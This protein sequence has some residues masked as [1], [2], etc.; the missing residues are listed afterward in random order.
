MRALLA[1][2]ERVYRGAFLGRTMPVLWEATSALGPEGW[3]V[4][5]LTDNYLRVTALAPEPLWNQI[6]PVRLTALN[7]EGLE[8][9]IS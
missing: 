9:I 4:S 6:M 1:D 5:G 8:G 2:A 7:D 3:R